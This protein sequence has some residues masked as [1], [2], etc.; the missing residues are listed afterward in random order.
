LAGTGASVRDQ[1][2]LTSVQAGSLLVHK[3]ISAR[4]LMEWSTA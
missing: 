1:A 3:R 2:T 4:L